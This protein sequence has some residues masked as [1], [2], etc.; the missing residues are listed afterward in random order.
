MVS[1]MPQTFRYEVMRH[2]QRHAERFSY[3]AQLR[4]L[5]PMH[6]HRHACAVIQL[7]EGCHQH[8]DFLRADRRIFRRGFVRPCRINDS[9]IDLDIN[10]ALFVCAP[11]SVIQGKV[12]NDPEQKADRLPDLFRNCS[13][14]TAKPCVLKD[15]FRLLTVA[16]NGRGIFQQFR[17]AVLIGHLD[18]LC[19][20]HWRR[21]L[22]P[23][24]GWQRISDSFN[25][26]EFHHI[27][28]HSYLVAT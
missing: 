20:R 19:M 5:E 17:P 12:T 22:T 7:R 11:P 10:I 24:T 8:T 26:S 3:L 1:A 6:F 18:R 4:I 13:R 28:N 25:R 9:L 27:K 23:R 15:V 16:C 14:C 21:S 2:G